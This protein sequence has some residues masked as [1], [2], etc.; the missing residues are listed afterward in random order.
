MTAKRKRFIAGATCPV[1]HSSDTLAVWR[2][3]NSD[4]VGCV[5]CGYSQ[6]QDDEMI[7][8]KNRTRNTLSVFFIRSNVIDRFFTAKAYIRAVF[9]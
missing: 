8:A 1:C 7:S 9:G 5:K 4:R 2:E 6:R 3:E